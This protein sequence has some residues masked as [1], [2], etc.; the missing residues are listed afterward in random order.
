[1][2]KDSK[3][4]A[5]YTLNGKRKLSQL[6]NHEK[7]GLARKF[8]ESDQHKTRKPPSLPTFKCIEGQN[9]ISG[10]SKSP[11]AGR[12]NPTSPRATGAPAR[13]DWDKSGGT[14]GDY[15]IGR[16]QGSLP[17]KDQGFGGEIPDAD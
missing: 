15:N 11:R 13:K 10:V 17:V 4:A 8:M 12:G 5:I 16:R 3:T 9:G 6:T 14:G 1:M 7:A 2:S